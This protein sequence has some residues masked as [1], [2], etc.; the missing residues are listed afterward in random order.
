MQP[1]YAYKDKELQKVNQILTLSNFTKWNQC[2]ISVYNQNGAFLLHEEVLSGYK[3]DLSKFEEKLDQII[4][5]NQA[6][7]KP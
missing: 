2:L 6:L 7:G 1:K 4:I 5:I 3:K